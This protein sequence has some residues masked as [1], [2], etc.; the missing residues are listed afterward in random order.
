MDGRFPLV[1][2]H[3]HQLGWLLLVVTRVVTTPTGFHSEKGG[4]HWK[5][6]FDFWKPRRPKAPCLL[7]FKISTVV[8]TL[9]TTGHAG[10]QSGNQAAAYQLHRAGWRQSTRANRWPV[11]RYSSSYPE[12]TTTITRPADVWRG[13]TVDRFTFSHLVTALLLATLV[14]G[15]AYLAVILM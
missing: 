2:A 3:G 15:G 13:G 5:P 7:A 9:V 11:S 6:T 1:T 8:T 4:F 12:C 14:V 10:N